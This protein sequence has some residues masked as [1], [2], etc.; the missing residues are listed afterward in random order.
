MQAV[1]DERVLLALVVETNSTDKLAAARQTGS[2]LSNMLLLVM[3]S[4]S[5][6]PSLQSTAA[7]LGRFC[8]LSLLQ[9]YFTQIY[10]QVQA[11]EAALQLI[12]QTLQTISPGIGCTAVER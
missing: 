6:L 11:N 12:A 5:A 4:R 8:R 10:A 7:S 2:S 1:I 3:K 9:Q